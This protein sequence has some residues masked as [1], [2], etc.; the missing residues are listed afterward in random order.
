MS[1]MIL[2]ASDRVSRLEPAPL[3]AGKETVLSGEIHFTTWTFRPKHRI[4]LSL[5]NAQFPM[6]WPSPHK[7][8]T[9]LHL[10]PDTRLELP[11]V[12]KNTLSAAC[13]LPK[14]DPEEWPPDA[15]YAEEKEGKSTNI[16]YNA[17]TGDAI[18]SCGIDQRMTIRD[19]QYHMQE[20]NTWKVNDKD[21]AR[22][23]YEATTTYT[24]TP[25]ER[26][27]KVVARFRMT[28]DEKDFILSETRQIWENQE[29]VREK[30]W[31]KTLPRKQH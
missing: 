28:S 24:V 19:T 14:P 20:K 23:S 10:G 5:A 2:K 21:P 16:D 30:K 7:G 12:E 3:E 31:E 25:P 11:V 17:E 1:G 4:R 18:Y 26:E 15:S 6:A 27:I 22:A 9:T 8:S 29:M 13:D